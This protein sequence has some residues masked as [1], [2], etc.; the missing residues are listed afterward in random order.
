LTSTKPQHDLSQIL[1]EEASR[2]I[3]YLKNPI[4][5][6][7]TLPDWSLQQTF[8]RQS[9]LAIF[10]G[11]LSGLLSFQF[12]AFLY[13][14]FLF[15]IIAIVVT[16]VLALFFYYYFQIFERK[17]VSYKKLYTLVV[18][19]NIPFLIF[20]ILS[21]YIAVINLVGTAMTGLI[22]VVG[23]NHNFAMEKRRAVRLVSILY[24]T[25]ALIWAYNQY[26]VMNL[27]SRF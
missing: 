6:I 3:K 5:G 13:G 16:P 15:P 9:G 19:A 14:I 4:E 18:L 17:T 21:N 11:G 25:L 23:L 20:H 10:S 12:F 1:K 26:E 22:L 7:H 24:I 2:L 27:R 8:F